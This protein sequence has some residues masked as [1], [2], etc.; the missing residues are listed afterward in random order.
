MGTPEMKRGNCYRAK[1]PAR[2][3]KRQD[4]NASA[5]LAKPLTTVLWSCGSCE[6]PAETLFSQKSLYQRGPYFETA[7]KEPVSIVAERRQ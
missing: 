2:A 5:L 4:F 7:R 1:Q 6:L 3:R